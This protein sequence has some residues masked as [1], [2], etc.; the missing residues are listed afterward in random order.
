MLRFGVVISYFC[1]IFFCSRIHIP[2]A[3]VGRRRALVHQPWLQIS[4]RESS[5]SWFLDQLNKLLHQNWHWVGYHDSW[6]L[7]TQ[8]SNR[9]IFLVWSKT[10]HPSHFSS[11]G[12]CERCDEVH[13]AAAATWTR[14]TK[15]LS[16][17]QD[18]LSIIFANILCS[19]LLFCNKKWSQSL[20]SVASPAKTPVIQMQWRARNW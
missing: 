5:P 11:Q 7:G 9:S 16:L 20:D 12:P 17:S 18:S 14:M 15:Y 13:D 4:E 1:T 3:A 19:N 8:L 6:S 10:I 2:T